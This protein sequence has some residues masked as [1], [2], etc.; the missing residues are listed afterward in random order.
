MKKNKKLLSLLL[1]LVMI[2]GLA[3]CGGSD[4]SSGASEARSEAYDSGYVY[5][6]NAAVEAPAAAEQ[7]MADYDAAEPTSAA[8]LG[9]ANGQ[10][11]TAEDM[12]EKIIYNA[13]VTLETT[14]FDDALERI[15][16]LVKEMGGYMEST[17][18]SGS[19]YSSISRG[20]VGARNAFYT[21]RIPSVRFSELIGTI[22]DLGNVPYSNTY[23]RNVTTQYYDTQS[24][25]DAYKVQEKRLLEMLSIAESVEDMLAIQKEL[26]EVQYEIDSLTGTLRYYD[27]Q[28]GY[29]TVSLTVNEVREYTPEP[30]I[31]LTYW[32][33][34]SKGFKESMHKT[35]EFFTEFF[36]WFVTSL[37]WL[38]PLGIVL[39]IV[40]ALLRRRAAR[41]PERAAARQARHE[42]RL[43]AK[44]AR[45]EAKLAKKNS[46]APTDETKP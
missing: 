7:A 46:S 2:A 29:S 13:D 10:V 44:A 22:S 11:P 3:G 20:K 42:A 9:S 37:P 12:S 35:A 45:R 19:N 26:T 8:G 14:A 40:V 25:L 15:A 34:M 39:W 16:A 6:T 27:N 32:E 41:N 28:V 4:K 31:Q 36:L 30:T 24:R 43:A 33:R 1:S 18:I 38:V 23:T 17:S 21:I 5:G